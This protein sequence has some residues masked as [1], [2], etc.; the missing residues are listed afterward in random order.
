MVRVID[1][2]GGQA[3]ILETQVAI[4][5]AR[6]NG[7]DLVEVAPQADPPVCRIM[8]FGRYKYEAKKRQVQAK[9]KQTVVEVKEIKIRPKTDVHD[10]EFKFRQAR[11]FLESGNKVK[12][13]VR[14]RGREIMYANDEA[15]RLVELIKTLEDVGEAESYPQREGRQI[16]VI[17][18][19]V[20]R[21]KGGEKA[22]KKTAA[23]TPEAETAQETNTNEEP[24]STD[25]EVASTEEEAKP[26]VDGDE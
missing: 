22:P 6:E 15:K 18:A 16:V 26:A 11:K 19:P 24:A 12:L 4:D 21:K 20:K 5:M 14:F 2:E 3:G 1:A 25:E 8:D 13:T 9:K 10:I 7:L 17:I 23:P